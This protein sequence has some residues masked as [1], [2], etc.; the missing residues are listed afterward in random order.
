[1][2]KKRKKK[3]SPTIG[4]SN[5]ISVVKRLAEFTGDGAMN[6]FARYFFER[7]FAEIKI[8]DDENRRLAQHSKS[9]VYVS[10]ILP[11]HKM[12]LFPLYNTGNPEPHEIISL[13]NCKKSYLMTRITEISSQMAERLNEISQNEGIPLA[14]ITVILSAMLGK[15]HNNAVPIPSEIPL[16]RRDD[17]LI[18]I[19]KNIYNLILE[20]MIVVMLSG[21]PG[22]ADLCNEVDHGVEIQGLK[23]RAMEMACCTWLETQ[24]SKINSIEELKDCLG[25]EFSHGEKFYALILLYASERV[26]EIFEEFA[27]RLNVDEDY[28]PGEP[29]PSAHHTVHMAP[30]T[31]EVFEALMRSKPHFGPKPKRKGVSPYRVMDLNAKIFDKFREKFSRNPWKNY[32][33]QRNLSNIKEY[34]DTSIRNCC[35]QAIEDEVRII[36]ELGKSFRTNRRY[37]K[38]IKDGM[39]D[40]FLKG[41][42]K[43]GIKNIKDLSD[44]EIELFNKY[45][46]ER[47]RHHRE[48]FLTQNQLIEYLRD[49]KEIAALNKKG[50]LLKKYSEPTLKKKLKI[51]IQTGEIKYEPSGRTYYYK[52]EDKEQI[53]Q[54]VANL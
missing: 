53:A 24:L 19:S 37:N 14:A 45:I 8:L 7:V 47:G 50:I 9:A 29:H 32:K 4:I 21:R 25:K 46:E 1:M 34:I 13:S 31:K 15:P 28:G 41:I 39:H 12:Q 20:A 35:S 30:E 42:N 3:G 43:F 6:C 48:G 22:W 27:A 38:E 33:L 23:T 52:E 10:H 49:V 44:I 5:F 11:L 54:A 18:E 36:A 51:L 40:A 26:F 2:S 16:P 17:F